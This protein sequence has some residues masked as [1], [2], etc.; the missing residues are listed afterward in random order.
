[1]N[2][3]SIDT[4]L[5]LIASHA[6]A[7]FVAWE[8]RRRS[9][10]RWAQAMRLECQQ[11]EAERLRTVD[12]PRGVHEHFRS[13]EHTLIHAQLLMEQAQERM[14]ERRGTEVRGAFCRLVGSFNAGQY[15]T[16]SAWSL[17]CP[18]SG[19]VWLIQARR[20][21]VA[22]Q[23]AVSATRCRTPALIPPE[24]FGLEQ[25]VGRLAASALS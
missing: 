12:K 18:I 19:S 10:L 1:M 21:G 17:N 16:F 23:Q 11:L 6:L 7:S 22:R 13:L 5:A 14:L 2:H 15:P 25:P 3:T 20:S 4:L 24:Q 9:T 8:L